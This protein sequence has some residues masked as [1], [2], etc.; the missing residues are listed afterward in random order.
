VKICTVAAAVAKNPYKRGVGTRPPFLAGRDE[1]LRRFARLLEDYPEKRGNFRITGLRGVGKTVLLKEFE[2]M[3]KREGWVVVRRDLST[4][5]CDEGAFATAIA[6]HMRD[7]VDQLSAVA[8]IK[9][10][11]ADATKSAIGQVTVDLGGGVTVSVGS[12][13]GDRRRS[14]LEDRLRV[15]LQ[16]LGVAARGPSIYPSATSH[17]CPWPGTP[18]EQLSRPRYSFSAHQK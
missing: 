12:G 2:R 14:V 11:V 3:A 16:E 17:G 8:R 7:A 6:D 10:K 15:A 5:L 9:G 1:Q 13:G 18:N 4:R